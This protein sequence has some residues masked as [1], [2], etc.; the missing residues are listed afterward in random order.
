MG[1]VR[2]LFIV[3]LL[4][5]GL[6]SADPAT[7]QDGIISQKS[8]MR[9]V[10]YN[11]GDV[12][13]QHVEI[14]IPR[15][16]RLD[17]STLPVGGK[18][19]GKFELR[20]TRVHS[21]DEGAVTRYT[22]VFDWQIFQVLPEVKPYPL[23]PLD[24]QFRRHDRVLDVHVDAPRVMVATFMPLILKK[25]DRA[26]QGDVATTARPTAVLER[27]ML[28]AATVLLLTIVYFCWYFDWLRLGWRAPRPFRRACRQIR[29]IARTESPER[30][31]MQAMRLLRH[32]FDATAGVALSGESLVRLFERSPRMLPLRQEIERF[33]CES[34]RAFFSGA[35]RADSI[36]ELLRFGR[37]LRALET[38]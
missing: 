36:A 34:E 9:S 1:A 38:L 33:Y 10:G 30:Q 20:S 19:S 4:G 14:I 5:C 25:E 22:L 15:G 13:E 17:E 16:Y 26:M 23:M 27:A 29:R 32:A 8:E 2:F 6:A 12:A 37:R 11:V 21:Q 3:L 18:N 24:L 35:S 28:A 31:S 7:D